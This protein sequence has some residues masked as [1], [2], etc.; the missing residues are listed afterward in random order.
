MGLLKTLLIIVLIYYLF[1]LTARFVSPF[2]LKYFINKTQRDF[3]NRENGY[4]K[5]HRKKE[6]EVSIDYIPKKDKKRAASGRK[7]TGDEG[8]YVDFEEVD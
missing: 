8:D 5:R 2:L 1:R 7:E 6:G 3:S 4:D